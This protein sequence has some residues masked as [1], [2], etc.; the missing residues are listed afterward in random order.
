ML[1][2][3]C[4]P[5]RGVSP[6]SMSEGMYTTAN[7]FTLPGGPASAGLN[8]YDPEDIVLLNEAMM[9]TRLG[10]DKQAARTLMK[11]IEL[12][13]DDPLFPHLLGLNLQRQEH[14]KAFN[15]QSIQHFHNGRSCR[16][17]RP[18]ARTAQGPRSVRTTP[19]R[20]E[21]SI[22]TAPAGSR[23][24]TRIGRVPARLAHTMSGPRPPPI[25]RPVPMATIRKQTARRLEAFKQEAAS[26]QS[27][28]TFIT[29]E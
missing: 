17:S 29:A 22:R 7:L 2:S 10:A 3:V 4:V 26:S 20:P 12:F 24:S 28:G 1:K 25:A 11:A 27:N 18:R 14:A 8:K 16:G 13:P 23:R 21:R 15:Q 6:R 19:T 5:L 9:F